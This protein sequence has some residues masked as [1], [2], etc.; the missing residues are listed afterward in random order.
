MTADKFIVFQRINQLH[1]M[2][3]MIQ[4]GLLSY[5]ATRLMPT[6]EPRHCGRVIAEANAWDC[7]IFLLPYPRLRYD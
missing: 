5:I 1:V 2:R 7:R 4:C 6:V 3:N